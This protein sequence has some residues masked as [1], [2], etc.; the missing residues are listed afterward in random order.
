VPH[1]LSIHTKFTSQLDSSKNTCQSRVFALHLGQHREGLPHP[2]RPQELH[3][4]TTGNAEGLGSRRCGP[5]GGL[6]EKAY[7][8]S[9]VDDPRIPCVL[10]SGH[11]GGPHHPAFEEEL[12]PKRQGVLPGVP[13]YE[14]ARIPRYKWF[15]F[16]GADPPC[17]IVTS[18]RR[19]RP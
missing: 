13:T 3:L 15:R 8:D 12:K 6:I 18:T 17:F 5:D 7:E 19:I 10:L 11:E 4:K 1:A 16:R 2:G 14:T 9:P